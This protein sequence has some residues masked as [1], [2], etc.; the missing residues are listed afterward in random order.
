MKRIIFGISLFATICFADPYLKE[1]IKAGEDIKNIDLSSFVKVDKNKYN[2]SFGETYEREVTYKNKLMKEVYSFKQNKLSII[3]KVDS[4][5]TDFSN[6]EIEETGN[7]KF[8]TGYVKSEEKE[9]KF[10]YQE[11]D[12]FYGM[13]NVYLDELKTGLAKKITA[14]TTYAKEI[15]NPNAEINSEKYVG[16]SILRSCIPKENHKDCKTCEF[17]ERSGNTY[18]CDTLYIN[19][20]LK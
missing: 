1:G 20:V 5:D 12:D 16:I 17:I 3:F 15:E 7:I 18:T 9:N 10:S 11:K 14:N 13:L 6:I 19:H 2:I 8:L 4:T